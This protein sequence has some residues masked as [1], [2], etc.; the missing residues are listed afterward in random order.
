VCVCE[1][2]RESERENFGTKV[3]MYVC[4]WDDKLCL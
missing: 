2:E 3:C 1:R 4:M